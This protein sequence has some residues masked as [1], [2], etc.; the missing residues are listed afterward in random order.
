MRKKLSRFFGIGAAFA[1]IL[2][3][4]PSFAGEENYIAR[5][6]GSWAGKGTAVIDAQPIPVT[7]KVSGGSVGSNRISVSG[8]CNAF[9]FGQP[10]AVDLTFDPATGV[11]RGTYIGDRVGPAKVTGKRHGNAVDFV[12]TWPK[13]VN[14]DTRADMTIENAGSGVLRIT[15]TDNQV[16]GGKYMQSSFVLSQL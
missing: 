9:I 3:T 12:I 14:G 16:P 5:F 1:G 7:C 13:P 11:Y 2:A 8:G 10:I 6:S 4:A 15:V